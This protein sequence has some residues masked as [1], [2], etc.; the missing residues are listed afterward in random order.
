MGWVTW[1]S[2]MGWSHGTV[3]WDGSHGM[4][5]WNDHMRLSHGMGHIGWSHGTLTWNNSHGMVTW[6]GSHEMVTWDGSHGMATWDGHMGWSHGM[7]TR[8]G[9]MGSIGRMSS[10]NFG[11]AKAHGRI[12]YKNMLPGII[13]AE[14]RVSSCKGKYLGIFLFQLIFSFI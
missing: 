13:R 14:L 7:V 4:V 9:H 3:T 2:H 8:D 6:D 10:M 1:D 12:L 5:T 11:T